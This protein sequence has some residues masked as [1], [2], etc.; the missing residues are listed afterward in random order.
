[1]IL[2]SV[3]TMAILSGEA[4]AMLPVQ[5]NPGFLDELSPRQRKIC[6]AI[7]RIW[8]IR[9]MNDFVDDRGNRL[10]TESYASIDA[11]RLF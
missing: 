2:V 4:L 1:M 8:D 9:D 6:M 7:A 11:N 10:S 3:T 5:C